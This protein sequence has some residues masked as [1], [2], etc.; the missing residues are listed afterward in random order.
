MEGKVE[1]GVETRG[2]KWRGGGKRRERSGDERREVERWR[3]EWKGRREVE[4]RVESGGDGRGKRRDG[5]K[6]RW[7]GNRGG[8][9][10]NMRGGRRRGGRKS[11]EEE[12]NRGNEKD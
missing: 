12:K 5:V 4:E 9:D 3:D 6:T 11:R 2:G 7:R 1:R 8:D 10:R